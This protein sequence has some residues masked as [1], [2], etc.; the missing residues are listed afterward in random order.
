VIVQN[1]KIIAKISGSTKNI[2]GSNNVTGEVK[3]VLEALKFLIRKK[4]K[5]AII[6]Y[7]YQG[8]EA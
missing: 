2:E 4:I 1:K 6:Y 8:I 5:D 3:A 7:D